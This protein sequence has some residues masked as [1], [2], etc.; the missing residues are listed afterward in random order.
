M[1]LYYFR[2]ACALSPH[3]VALE[4][5][6]PLDIVSIDKQTKKTA[7]GKDYLAINSKGSVPALELDDG[8]VLTEGPAIVQYLADLKPNA[9]LAPAR[10][11]FERYQ[12]QE[13]LNYIGS[14][15][16]KGFSPLFNPVAGP[17]WKAAALSA[18][19]KK[20]DWLEIQLTGKQFLLGESF[21]GADAYLFT[22][23][24]W[25]KPM[26]IALDAWPALARYHAA[27]A[28][29]PKVQEAMRAEG[30]A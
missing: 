15:V 25:T 24:N 8:R 23:L 2:G 14:E 3:I 21:T 30:L 9:K 19:K 18:L 12:L 7:D 22:V 29:R 16:H 26:K 1:K 4:A 28:A 27:I 17:E 13:M 6:I 10:D 5:G 11:S 20:F